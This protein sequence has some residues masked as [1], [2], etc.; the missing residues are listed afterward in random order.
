MSSAVQTNFR[1]VRALL[2]QPHDVN[3]ETLKRT[4]ERLGVTVID[5]D[6]A[7][8]QD[9]I[10]DIV[11]FD[12]DVGCIDLGGGIPHVALVGLEAPSRLIKVARQR[13]VAHLMKPVRSNGVF[14]ALLIAFNEQVSRDRDIE[15][16]DQLLRRAKGRR[17]VFKAVLHLMQQEQIDD[18]EAYRRLRLGSMRLRIS[19]EEFAA[20]FL[21][22]R[23]SP[24]SPANQAQYGRERN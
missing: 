16:R 12:A 22:A 6:S 23:S 14:T 15:E 24:V 3:H 13:C 4:L 19:V 10:F 17:A 2:I 8:S 20:N 21:A 1:G 18:D 9:R 5:H 11:F 7:S